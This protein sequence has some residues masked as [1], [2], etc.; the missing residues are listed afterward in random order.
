MKLLITG[1]SGFVGSNLVDY[2]TSRTDW[3]VHSLGRRKGDVSTHDH[4][5]AAIDSNSDYSEALKGV[6]VVVHCA[7]QTASR[8]ETQGSNPFLECNVHGT[9]NLA[10]QAIQAGVK[11][12]IFIS[13]IKVNG[14]ST[15]KNHPFRYADQHQ[16]KD[17][18]GESK[19]LAEQQLL[20]LANDMEIVVIRP[21]LVYGSGVKGN[22][23]SLLK[24]VNKGVPLPFG[25]INDNRRSLV[26]VTN[27]VDLI[28]TCVEHPDA[29]NQVFLVSDDNDISTATMVREM[30]KS[31]DKKAYLLPVPELCYQVVGRMLNKLDVINRLVGSLQVDITH[32]KQTLNWTPPQ[33]LSAGFKQAANALLDSK[34]K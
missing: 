12:F 4:F 13:S 32:T 23:S 30:A 24:L 6:D 2:I 15:N 29:A 31:L 7:A 21:T 10:R 1:C 34:E 8:S 17:H 20:E 28:V 19:S 16:P 14:E 25:C 18:Y 33:T 9:L 22:F 27:L 11:R 26:S 3:L 5:L